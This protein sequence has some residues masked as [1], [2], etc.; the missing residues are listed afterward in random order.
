MAWGN[1]NS[2]VLDKINEARLSTQ[3]CVQM[4]I[5]ENKLLWN[6]IQVASLAKT[7]S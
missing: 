3:V 6:Y 5:L 2:N 1:Q 4:T 7:F